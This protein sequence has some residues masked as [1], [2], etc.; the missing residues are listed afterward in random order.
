MNKMFNGKLANA[1]RLLKPGR[2]ITSLIAA[3]LSLCMMVVSSVAWLTTNRRLKAEEMNMAIAVDDTGAVY[4]AYM[5]DLDNMV[6]ID[7]IKGESGEY[8]ELSI[9]NLDMNQYDTIFSVQNKYTPAFARIKVTRNTSMPEN[10]TV[11]I[12]VDRDTSIGAFNSDGKLA[13]YISSMLRFTAIIDST[14]N[15]L[16]IT[17]ANELYNHINTET[18]FNEIRK[19]K[20][21]NDNSKTFVSFH[22][23]GELHDHEK[24]DTITVGVPY[25][26]DDWYIDGDGNHALNVYLY[27]S[28]DVQLIECYLKEHSGDRISLDGNEYEFENDLKKVAVSYLK[29]SD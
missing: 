2:A 14:K 20:G 21:D 13:D 8:E 4:R 1:L 25:T 22:G 9:S 26:E 27:M 29:P 6:G 17:D 28:Y 16:N 18:R 15:D 23:E 11:L 5:F 12:T 10:G 24:A 7:R 19:Y 3:M